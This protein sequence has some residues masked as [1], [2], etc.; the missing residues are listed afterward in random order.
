MS[1]EEQEQWLARLKETAGASE[2]NWYVA[3]SLSLFFGLFGADMFY[4]DRPW[5][6]LFK[7]ATA[8]GG[9]IWWIVDV[10][11]VFRGKVRDGYGGFLRRPC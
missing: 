9:G 6:G 8:G 3:F 10:I 5:L 11:R 4:L 1:S 2:K 7:L